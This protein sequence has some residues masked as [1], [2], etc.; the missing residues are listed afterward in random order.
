MS[1][2]LVICAKIQRWKTKII[3]GNICVLAQIISVEINNLSF[4]LISGYHISKCAN[5]PAWKTLI[6][7]ILRARFRMDAK[8]PNSRA[9]K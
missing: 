4:V 8:T 1:M 7:V 5:N 3:M 2:F 6:I 9:Q